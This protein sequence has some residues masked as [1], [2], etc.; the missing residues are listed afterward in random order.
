MKLDPFT[1]RRLARFAQT[2]RDKN[3]QL[4]TLAD[5]EA[6]GF[7]KSVVAQAVKEEFLL[8]LYV[9]LTSGAVVKGY[10]KKD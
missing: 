7:E 3:A 8:E 6:E 10:K 5:F 9:N 2:F 4:P 1:L